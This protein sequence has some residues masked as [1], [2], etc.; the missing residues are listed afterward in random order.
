MRTRYGNRLPGKG[1]NLTSTKLT[2]ENLSCQFGDTE[3]VGDVSLKVAAGEFVSIV[4]A[5][6]CGKSTIFNV[7]AGLVSPTSGRV[8]IEGE[9]VTGTTGHVGYMLQKDLLVPW[10]T[11]VGNIVMRAAL[12]RRVTAADEAEAREI[13]TRY[14]LGEFLNHYPHALSGGMR[15]R[16]ALMRTLA[17]GHELMLL[18]EPFGALDSQTRIDMQRWLLG[19]WSETKKTV[20]FVTH[21][22]D[23]S[24][25]LSD[26]VIVMTP[27]PGRIA[28]EIG[29]PLPRPRS[30]DM[31]TDPQF[32]TIKREIV[33]LLH[34]EEI[35]G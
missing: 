1:G 9:D 6:G 22:V 23:E 32:M 17:M 35:S 20:L 3:A 15:Q 33:R 27:R 18:D 25:F 7:V 30:L 12:T 21:D 19:V 16:V 26:R 5:S 29:I 28:A 4:G 2:I 24:I 10:R 31:V 14:G 13:A 11:V 8:H 34:A